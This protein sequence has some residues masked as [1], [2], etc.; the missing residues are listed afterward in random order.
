[1]GLI[2]KLMSKEAAPK[3]AASNDKDKD[4]ALNQEE[5]IILLHAMKGATFKGETLEQVYNL[6]LKLQNVLAFLIKK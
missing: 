6:T 2:D 1:M 3:K 4:L 5:V